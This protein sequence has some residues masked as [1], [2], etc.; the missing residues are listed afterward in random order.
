MNNPSIILAAMS[1]AGHFLG[2]LPAANTHA[3]CRKGT[4]QIQANAAGDSVDAGKGDDEEVTDDGNDYGIRRL[5]D[6]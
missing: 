1:K 3:D 2:W 4:D 5:R 6:L